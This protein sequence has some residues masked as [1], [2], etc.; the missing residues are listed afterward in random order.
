M[1]TIDIIKDMLS[2]DMSV[3]TQPI[4]EQLGKFFTDV[5]VK[6]TVD[7]AKL[8]L[9]NLVSTIVNSGKGLTKSAIV[10]SRVYLETLE[11]LSSCD[12]STRYYRELSHSS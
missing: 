4:N 12:L 7:A 6:A 11:K 9:K 3:S 2:E 1:K 10:G 5:A 8:E